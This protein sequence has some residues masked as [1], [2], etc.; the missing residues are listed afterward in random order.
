MSLQ[1]KKGSQSWL[2]AYNPKT[3]KVETMH[4][5]TIC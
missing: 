1:I 2:K 4:G 5:T 3:Q